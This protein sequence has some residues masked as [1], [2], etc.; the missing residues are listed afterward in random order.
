MAFNILGDA[1]ELCFDPH[2]APIQC[3]ITG[4]SETLGEDI[5]LMRPPPEG[6]ILVFG[7]VATLGQQYIHLAW[8]QLVYW[9]YRRITDGSHPLSL[10]TKA[11]ALALYDIPF[12]EKLIDLSLKIP[13]PPTETRRA[14]R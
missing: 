9:T 5:T 7:G 6:F 13:A 10:S 2:F 1:A 11:A 14:K 3:F 12:T 4:V 8:Q